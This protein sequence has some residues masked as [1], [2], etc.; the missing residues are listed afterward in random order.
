MYC[1]FMK[2]EEIL[3]GKYNLDFFIHSLVIDSVILIRILVI[4]IMICML[5]FYWVQL[6]R[7][8]CSDI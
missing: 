3:L 4:V 8:Q 7:T 2:N 6:R 5:C 1:L